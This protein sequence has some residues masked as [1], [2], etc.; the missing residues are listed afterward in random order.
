MSNDDKPTDW[1]TTE[2]TP[3]VIK[4][5]GEKRPFRNVPC[6]MTPEELAA[7]NTEHLDAC[8]KI[9]ELQREKETYKSRLEAAQGIESSI[10]Q[11]CKSGI[12]YRD[13]ECREEIVGTIAKVIRNDTNQL[14]ESRPLSPAERQLMLASEKLAAEQAGKPKVAHLRPG[15]GKDAGKLVEADGIVPDEEGKKPKPN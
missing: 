3:I 9:A 14:V 15:K 10:R 8:D 7:K 5:E 13:I 1:P 2:P 12:E 11:V 6:T 4:R